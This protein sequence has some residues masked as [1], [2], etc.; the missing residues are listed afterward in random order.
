MSMLLYMPIVLTLKRSDTHSIFW[1]NILVSSATSWS[2]LLMYNLR[3][4]QT[5]CFKHLSTYVLNIS[6]SELHDKMIGHIAF[7]SFL[8]TF[9]IL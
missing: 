4:S 6:G 5:K 8:W 1:G 3:H 9:H 7:L 2:A